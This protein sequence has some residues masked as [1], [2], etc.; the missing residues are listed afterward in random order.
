MKQEIKFDPLIFRAY[1]VRGIYGKTLDEEIMKSI[2]NAFGQ[3]AGD[4][5]VG[6]D[7]RGS[8]IPLAQA[9]VEGLT[10]S[11]HNAMI[12]GQT[13]LAATCFAGWKQ[14]INSAYITASH[15]TKEWNGIKFFDRQ[16][17]GLMQEGTFRIRDIVA[18][19]KYAKKEKKI[20]QDISSKETIEKYIEHI[21]SKI[22]PGKKI[23]L[24]IDCGN[25]AAGSLAPK[26]F[27][28]A[29]FICK[30]IFI[31]PDGDFPNRLPDPAE[32]E[33]TE[34]S[35]NA[36]NA[37]MGIAYDGDGDRL[38]I[39]DERGRKLTP[40]Q[41]SYIILMDLLEKEKGHVVANVECTRMIDDAAKKFSRKVERIPVG[42][43]YMMQAVQ[44][45]K[46]AF[47][48]ERSG[49]Y[50]IPLLV[51][52]DDSIAISYYAACVLSKSDKKLSEI[53]D[54]MPA[55]P[56]ERLN[57]ECDDK[58][59]F[60]TVE[61]IKQQLKKQNNKES[62]ARGAGPLKI[63]DMDGVRVDFK[64]GWILIRASNTGPSIRLT[65]EAETKERL[66]ELKKEFSEMLEEGIRSAYS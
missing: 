6:W 18:A 58:E 15:L 36:K 45:S 29:G 4:C 11:G 38:V 17:V 27:E 23:K 65:I 48:V 9:F 20:T 10:D 50:A 55:Y 13:P 49:H 64:D 59:K 34:L 31:E 62:D 42:H 30:N 28:K 44:K 41:I 25:G 39:M 47:G 66:E 43:T 35:K 37:Y 12:I 51:P 40:E 57:F 3:I 26:L 61:R 32:D 52:F 8:S 24:I 21:I 60:S 22:K 5:V 56:F 33:L 46:A 54:E 63:N 2:G 53:V 14:N 16:G 7:V 19:S 1:D